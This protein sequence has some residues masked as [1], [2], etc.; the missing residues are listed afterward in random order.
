MTVRHVQALH[1]HEG[2]GCRLGGGARLM[3]GGRTLGSDGRTK[4]RAGFIHCAVEVTRYLAGLSGVPH[5]LHHRLISHLNTVTS[6]LTC[7][8]GVGQLPGASVVVGGGVVTVAPP[9]ASSPD[10]S[11]VTSTTDASRNVTQTLGAPS[12]PLCRS[13][14]PP[15]FS[16]SAAVP[17]VTTSLA[18][19]TSVA[20]VPARLVPQQTTQVL[21]SSSALPQFP[22]PPTATQSTL[23]AIT[24][25]HTPPDLIIT[26]SESGLVPMNYQLPK[27][28][29]VTL[30]RTDTSS[31]EAAS[32][33]NSATI[34]AP[35]T[36]PLA[37][38]TLTPLTDNMTSPTSTT[39]H[40]QK[41]VSDACT[42]AV[43]SVKQNHV[44]AS[45][46]SIGDPHLCEPVT[47]CSESPDRV[48]SSRAVPLGF[49]VSVRLS[50][51]TSPPLLSAP[52]WSSPTIVRPTPT[53][54]AVSQQPSSSVPPLLSPPTAPSSSFSPSSSSCPSSPP[55]GSGT[56]ANQALPQHA[57]ALVAPSSK[58]PLDLATDRAKKSVPRAH[59]KVLSAFPWSRPA[60]YPL[61][62]RLPPGPSNPW[63]PW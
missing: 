61:P 3:S 16:G 8:P 54:P 13:S 25:P 22:Q 57:P 40:A 23:P 43:T 27:N 53:L 5:D 6:S 51:A 59:L 30:P 37:S 11:G 33:V 50:S 41:N 14:P 31:H 17:A 36:F 49:Q 58:E 21:A 55:S 60:P 12:A 24:K 15:L 35:Q 44:T 38:S 18:S 48:S 26:N 62:Q 28:V 56:L 1:R 63:R 2:V 39:H 34:F 7:V 46:V 4:Y 10:V 9:A 52:L 29:I 42:Q 45:T 32:N 47:L 20:F 19:G